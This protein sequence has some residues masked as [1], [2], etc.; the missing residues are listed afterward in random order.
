MSNNF[1]SEF[2][3]DISSE[4]LYNTEVTNNGTQIRISRNMLAPSCSNY[5]GSN[6]QRL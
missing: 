4:Y 1:R 6:Q 5:K 3:K 2:E